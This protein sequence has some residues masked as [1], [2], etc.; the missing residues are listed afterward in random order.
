MDG[1]IGTKGRR[2]E[3]HTGEE[4][5]V[6]PQRETKLEPLP[7]QE[8]HMAD[9][10][11][12]TAVVTRR[13]IQDSLIEAIPGSYH[14][15]EGQDLGPIRRTTLCPL[16]MPTTLAMIETHGDVT[17]RGP[18]NDPVGWTDRLGDHDHAN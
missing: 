4:I 5:G 2:T 18:G 14:P 9:H 15:T 17:V 13:H 12:Q 10:R 7:S 6:V 8:I 16:M 3:I 1:D 11:I